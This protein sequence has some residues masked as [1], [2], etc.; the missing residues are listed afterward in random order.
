MTERPKVK[1]D[2]TYAPEEIQLSI[3]Q[4]LQNLHKDIPAE[5]NVRCLNSTFSGY[6]RYITQEFLIER[7]IKAQRDY[8]LTEWSKKHLQIM[9]DHQKKLA[10]EQSK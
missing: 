6:A 9:E 2:K 7:E 5:V 8:L 4:Q 1:I 10:K 3:L